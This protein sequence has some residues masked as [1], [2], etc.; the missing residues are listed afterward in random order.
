MEGEEIGAGDELEEHVGGWN[1]NVPGD[2]K[3]EQ[4]KAIGLYD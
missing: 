4:L 3:R 2:N 1:V